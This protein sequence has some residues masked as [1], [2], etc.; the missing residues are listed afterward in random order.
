MRC[1]L[2]RNQGRWARLLRLGGIALIGIAVGRELRM[3][4]SER[5]W[6]GYLFGR[7]PYDF[8]RPTAQRIRGE[9]WATDN[10]RLFLPRAFGVGWGLNFGRLG[11]LARDCA[12][13]RSRR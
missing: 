6:H 9:F 7:I 12:A 8:R 4:A 3:P 5:E 10:P 2:R 11:V 1:R 13:R